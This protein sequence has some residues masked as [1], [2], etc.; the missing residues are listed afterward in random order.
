[1]DERVRILVKGRRPPSRSSSLKNHQ[2]NSYRLVDREEKRS[3]A[4]CLQ[5]LNIHLLLERVF[6]NFPGYSLTL[7]QIRA[8]ATKRLQKFRNRSHLSGDATRIYEKTYYSHALPSVVSPLYCCLETSQTGDSAGF[9]ISGVESRQTNQEHVSRL[10]RAPHSQ[11]TSDG[12]FCQAKFHTYHV[13]PLTVRYCYGREVHPTR[14]WPRIRDACRFRVK[15]SSDWSNVW[16]QHPIMTQ[17]WL[18]T[19]CQWRIQKASEFPG[20]YCRLR[21]MYMKC[22][23]SVADFV[24]G[25]NVPYAP[26]RRACYDYYTSERR[27]A[28]TVE[29]FIGETP[30]EQ[31]S[32]TL[33]CILFTKQNIHHFLERVS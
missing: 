28:F 5:K 8:N 1:P 33:I 20:R 11:H 2:L 29:L 15:R 31:G 13:L 24:L 21:S 9:Q 32:K 23:T 3:Y 27:K 17:Y 30:T 18:N 14:D 4:S 12:S 10:I 19:G 25:V 7:A 26:L 16:T 6:L 22:F